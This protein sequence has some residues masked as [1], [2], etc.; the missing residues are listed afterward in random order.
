M[1]E[2]HG[3]LD[4]RRL[5]DVADAVIRAVGEIA[6]KLGGPAPHPLAVVGTASQP[7]C[8]ANYAAWEVE[9]GCAFLTRLGYL[10]APNTN[11]TV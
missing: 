2:S 10:D 4:A 3:K 8:L 6:A 11:K 1:A 9:Q 5:V 7:K